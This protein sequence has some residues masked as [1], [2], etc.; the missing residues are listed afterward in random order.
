MFFPSFAL[1]SGSSGGPGV[2]ASSVDPHLVTEMLK[3][4]VTEIKPDGTVMV[5]DKKA[6][7]EHVLALD[8]DTKISAQD[9]KAFGGRKELERGDLEVGQRLKVVMRQTNGEVLRVKIL[10][11]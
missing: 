11:S 9:K 2:S 3:C 6:E 5:R 4:V 8:R 1:A 7:T 10:K